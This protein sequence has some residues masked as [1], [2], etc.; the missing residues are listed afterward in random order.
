MKI[1]VKVLLTILNMIYSIMKLF[2]VGEKITFVSRQSDKKSEDMEL[3]ER[4][5]RRKDPGL[6]QFFLCKKLEGGIFSKIGYCFHVFKQMYHIATS[7]VVVLDSYCISVSALKQRESLVVIQMWHALGS[8]KKFGFSIVGEGEGRN[9]KLADVF[10]MHRNYTYILTSSRVCAPN[11]AEAFGY[12]DKHMKVMTLPRV[13]KLTDWS[14]KEDYLRRI[15]DEYPEFR[16]KKVVVY[17]PTLRV[18]RNISEAVQNLAAAF[19]DSQYIFVLK[20]H[21]LM[22]VN[23][24]TGVVDN[25]FTTLEM[26]FAADYVICDYSAIIFEAAIIGKP[27]FFYTFDYETYGEERDFYMDYDAEMPGVISADP[28]VLA[29]AVAA[30]DYSIDRIKAFSYKYVEN[31]SA[32]TDKLAEFITDQIK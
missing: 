1:V 8:L 26:L 30:D 6:E 17:A 10:S 24:E 21:P 15:Y 5:I 9:A 23:S 13:D 12:D 25:K 19:S 27:L 32:C 20:K 14:F 3:L 7:K 31:Q 4:S 22:Q 16:E 29:E 18:D 2:P 11:F 28:R